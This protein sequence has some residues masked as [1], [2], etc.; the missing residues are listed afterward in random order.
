MINLDK[1]DKSI[2]NNN[3]PK[4]TVEETINDKAD[5]AYHIHNSDFSYIFQY[6][7]QNNK[8]GCGITDISSK[9]GIHGEF[10]WGNKLNHFQ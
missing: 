4:H 8:N 7:A 6:E 10:L 9:V 3:R 2:R 1:A 5:T